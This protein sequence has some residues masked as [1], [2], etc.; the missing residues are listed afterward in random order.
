MIPNEFSKTAIG[1]RS[2][3]KAVTCC[4]E[5]NILDGFDSNDI[6]L[7]DSQNSEVISYNEEGICFTANGETYIKWF[8]VK[9]QTYYFLTFSG[10]V[11]FPQWT[12][13]YFGIIDGDGFPLENIQ[14]KRELDF[15]VFHYGVDQQLTI[16]GQDGEWYDRTY[17][18][19]SGNNE[20]MGFFMEGSQG[21]VILRTL[22]LME[23]K[24]ARITENWKESVPFSWQEPINN[25]LEEDNYLNELQ[26]FE[27]YQ[28]DYKFISINENKIEYSSL[29]QGCYCLFWLPIPEDNIFTFTY[30]DKVIEA[31]NASYGFISQDK[32]GKRKW[33]VQ[34]NASK[35]HDYEYQCDAFCVPKGNKVAFAVFDGGGKAEFTDFKIFLFGKGRNTEN[36]Y[37]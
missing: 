31:G 24:N 6:L 35:I 15:F 28:A 16:K 32:N 34:K 20:K 21:S 11:K 7:K 19:N 23:G 25:C 8:D 22:K 18:F 14:T 5:D 36:T 2:L 12:D 27:K 3:F 10:R 30:K 4:N 17:L 29:E 9:P 13:I 26:V 1:R 33:L 37:L